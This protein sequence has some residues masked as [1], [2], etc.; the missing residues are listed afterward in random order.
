MRK[1]TKSEPV[2]VIAAT[3]T[4]KQ[5]QEVVGGLNGGLNRDIIRRTA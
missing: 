1:N 5:L 4:K 3:L 2:T